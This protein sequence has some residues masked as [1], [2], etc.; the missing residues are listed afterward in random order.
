MSDN[1]VFDLAAYRHAEH[2][3]GETSDG[4]LPTTG[5]EYRAAL[6]NLM[7][8]LN[9]Q[10]ADSPLGQARVESGVAALRMAR[11]LAADLP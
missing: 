9:S 10:P 7:E 2:D 4:E 11:R 6:D 8:S 5:A 1:N 3:Q